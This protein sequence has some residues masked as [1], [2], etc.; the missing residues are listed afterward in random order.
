MLFGRT[1]GR[2]EF[3]AQ[4]LPW[5]DEIYRTGVGLLGS[6]EHA[7]DLAQD[8][9]LNAWKSFDRFEKGTNI[10]AW[11]HKILV[12]RASHFRRKIYKEAPMPVKGDPED[13]NKESVVEDIPVDIEVPDYFSDILVRDAVAKLPSSY[14]ETL[15]L[16]DV[17]DFSYKEVAEILDVPIGTVMSRLNR[18]RRLLRESLLALAKEK[19]IE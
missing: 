12:H 1:G 9:Y 4:A 18:G 2:E 5:L 3:D 13:G 15:L 14:R 10:R 17:R 8:V 6:R 11:L 7:E 16:A 19:G